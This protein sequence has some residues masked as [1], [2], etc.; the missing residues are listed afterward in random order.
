MSRGL[1]TAAANAVQSEVPLRTVAAE[2]DFG[3][4][5]V[6]VNGSPASIWIAG[7]EF[8][9]VGGLGAISAVE[10]SAEM[11]SY[12]LTMTLSGVPRDIVATALTEA[13]QGRRVTVWEVFIDRT[14]WQPIAD[15]TIVFRGRLSQMNVELGTLATVEVTIE[16]R[17]VSWERPRLRRYTDE[18]QQRAHPG[19]VGLQFVSTTTEKNIVWPAKTFRA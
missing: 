5:F 18:D 1:S 19:D 7:N 4:G 10:E 2:L 14:T 3:S 13:Y 16:N 17:L 11:K 12:G 9:G 8:L 15:P 6:R